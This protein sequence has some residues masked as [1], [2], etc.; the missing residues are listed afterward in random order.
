MADDSHDDL[1]PLLIG[2]AIIGALIY[3]AKKNATA[4]GAGTG[5]SVTP[6]SATGVTG[7]TS[8]ELNPALQPI[9][10]NASNV[11][12]PSMPGVTGGTGST[13]PFSVTGMTY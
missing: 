1:T 9:S 10:V 5:I 6:S 13:N 8:A 3:F 2:V 4:A 12:L 11:P 7:A